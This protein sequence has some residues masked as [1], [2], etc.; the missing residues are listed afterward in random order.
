MAM[1]NLSLSIKKLHILAMC[2]SSVFIAS[3]VFASIFFGIPAYSQEII[4]DYPFENETHVQ[5]TSDGEAAL[6]PYVYLTLPLIRDLDG[7]GFGGDPYKIDS[8]TVQFHINDHGKLRI[9]EFNLTKSGSQQVTFSDTQIYPS[10][11][12]KI[13]YDTNGRFQ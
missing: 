4:S 9:F 3:T 12:F 5:L 13:P 10:F 11:S 2:L 1:M 6:K 8:P 7:Y